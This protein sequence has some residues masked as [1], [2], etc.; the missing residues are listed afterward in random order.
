MA[1][2]GLHFGVPSSAIAYLPAA[3]GLSYGGVAL[4]A[5]P[6]S[7][8]FGRK[9]PL[10]LG[11]LSFAIFSALIPAAP[12]LGAAIA[13]SALTGLCAAIIQPNALSLVADLSPP[14]QIG[15]RIGNVFIGLMLAFM[16]TPAL[17]GRLADT[18][19]WASAYYALSALALAAFSA[20]SMTF[21]HDGQVKVAGRGGL[22]IFLA[23]HHGA[24]A[25][26]G[27]RWRLSASY[28]WL[29]WVAGFGAVVAEVAS[30][31]L[32]MTTTQAG[33]IAGFF[34]LIVIAGNL[35]N[36]RIQR[37]IGNAALPVTALAS[38]LGVLLF[39]LPINS[40]A[41]LELMGIPWAFGYGCAGPLHHG[42]L[43]ALS[44]RYR[45]T[46]NSYHA[47]LLNLG[48]FSV[49]GLMGALAP[50]ASL[51]I[52]CATVGT[53]ALAGSGLLWRTRPPASNPAAG[54]ATA[55]I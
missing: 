47:S 53:I 17:A 33:L 25:T 48:I 39:L 52:F 43:S 50:I 12:T 22:S 9:R 30:R 51:S 29:G 11:L 4:F 13:L 37:L 19:G 10:Q 55:V 26:P 54:P 3:Y 41:Q 49:S 34:G 23:T 15:R 35:C 45:G 28:L 46:V 44:D 14:D 20:T 38:A 31:K 18:S 8:R 2:M 36:G 27:V 40:Q 24:L 5:G 6:L 32:N 42:R 7:D 1:L 21:E 16:L